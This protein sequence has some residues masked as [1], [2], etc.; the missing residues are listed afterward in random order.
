M[1]NHIHGHV[2]YTCNN[3]FT[4]SEC[5]KIYSLANPQERKR[6]Q[7]KQPEGNIYYTCTCT[8]II[9]MYYNYECTCTCISII[10]YNYIHVY[11]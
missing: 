11:K 4:V 5:N 7:N 6:S 1:Y 10:M 9:G 2:F 3:V 8:F